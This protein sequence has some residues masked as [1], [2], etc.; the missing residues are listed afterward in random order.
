MSQSQQLGV[1]EPLSLN[2]PTAKDATA[3]AQLIQTLKAANQFEP[4]RD[5][6]LRYLSRA[7]CPC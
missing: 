7:Q 6:L 3:T 1:T 2:K 5:A 4:E